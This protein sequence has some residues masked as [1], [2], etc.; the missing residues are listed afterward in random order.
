[1]FYFLQG[2]IMRTTAR[3]TTFK[4]LF[5]SQFV[6]EIEPELK[7]ALYKTDNLDRNDVEYCE[8]LLNT[9][10]EHKE[11]ISEL[12]DKKSLSFP[13]S[14]LYPADKSV[15]LIA[16]AEILYFD[17]IPDKVSINEAANI[18]SK[19]SSE[20]SASFIS[21]ILSVIVAEKQAK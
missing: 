2:T 17:D 21:G 6:D 3:E 19:Y 18:A 5:S 8:K 7:R 13:E 16:V 10:T 15:L 1:M 9:I 4:I 11:E 14:R 12:I 20:R